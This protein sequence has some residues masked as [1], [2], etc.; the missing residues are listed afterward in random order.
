MV[1]I[2]VHSEKTFHF[3]M[4]Y[5]G[6]EVDKVFCV[7]DSVTSEGLCDVRSCQELLS[8]V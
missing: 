4:G 6:L 1:A 7:T 3:V 5:Q 2:I 8:D